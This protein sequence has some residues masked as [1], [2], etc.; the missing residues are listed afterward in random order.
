MLLTITIYS[1]YLIV[2]DAIRQS[3]TTTSQITTKPATTP[4]INI[5]SGHV[6]G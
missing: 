1:I 4:N 5:L 2:I 6:I 3:V